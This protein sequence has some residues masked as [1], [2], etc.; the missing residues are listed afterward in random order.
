MCPSVKHWVSGEQGLRISHIAS[1][2]FRPTR[3]VVMKLGNGQTNRNAK[4]S[5][6]IWSEFGQRSELREGLET[7]Y[8]GKESILFSR[9][10][11]SFPTPALKIPL[12]LPHK[13]LFLGGKTWTMSRRPQHWKSAKPCLCPAP[14]TPASLP[15][16]SFS[17]Q[18]FILEPC[19][20]TP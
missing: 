7:T 19:C 5:P 2:A 10:R 3:C 1:L 18:T 11:P 15:K 4:S 17:R 8:H 13:V 9:T 16:S 6:E 12:N 20:L 14:F